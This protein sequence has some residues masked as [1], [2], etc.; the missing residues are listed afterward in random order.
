VRSD[1]Q[2]MPVGRDMSS[3]GNRIAHCIAGIVSQFTFVQDELCEAGNLWRIV[4][5]T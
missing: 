5:F 2:M 3:L 4:A 1:P